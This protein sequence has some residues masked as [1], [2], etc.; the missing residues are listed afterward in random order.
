MKSL[1]QP[2]HNNDGFISIDDVAN[3]LCVSPRTVRR[4][5]A[6]GLLP[7][8][9]FSSKLVRFRAE[10]VMA[11]FAKVRVPAKSET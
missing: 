8:Y 11:A 5:V 9:R 6:D 2:G 1:A 10:E 4:L 3:M 7:I